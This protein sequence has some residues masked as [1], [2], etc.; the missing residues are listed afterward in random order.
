MREPVPDECR[1]VAYRNHGRLE[2]AIELLFPP[3]KQRRIRA[4]MMDAMQT[5]GD[6]IAARILPIMEKAIRGSLPVIESGLQRS[7]S[8]H[9]VEIDR[10]ADRWKEG[11]CD[12]TA[13]SY[14]K[15]CNCADR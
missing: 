6:A 13:C 3:E 10:L 7:F 11:G 15:K 1:F 2:D 14:G 9:R 8:K 5:H 4:L 12:A